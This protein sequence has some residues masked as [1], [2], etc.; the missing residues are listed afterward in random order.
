MKA[1]LES[2]KVVCLQLMV[3][4]GEP[5]VY[6]KIQGELTPTA[7]QKQ[8]GSFPAPHNR[9]GEGWVQMDGHSLHVASTQH[10]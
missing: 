7:S 3:L 5:K 8:V 10:S 6:L 4:E 2:Q 9:V 1:T